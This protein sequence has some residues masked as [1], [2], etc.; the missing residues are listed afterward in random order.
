MGTWSVGPFDNDGAACWA[1][2]LDDAEPQER[3]ALVRAALAEAADEDDYLRVDTA[4]VAI[5]AAAVVAACR[6]DGLEFE[7]AF[8]P[9]FLHAPPDERCVLPDDLVTLALRALDRVVADDS[10]WHELRD[11]SGGLDEAMAA[12]SIVRESLGG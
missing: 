12:L 3:T 11:D 5:A 2:E 6:A 9:T 8:A 1:G 7:S 4:E 10:E